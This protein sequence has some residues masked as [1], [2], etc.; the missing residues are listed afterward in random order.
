MHFEVRKG[1]NCL[2]FANKEW[3]TLLSVVEFLQSKTLR[4]KSGQLLRLTHPAVDVRAAAAPPE[5][6]TTDYYDGSGET[7]SSNS[8]SGTPQEH[9]S[10][11]AAG[12]GTASAR[13]S[14]GP[15][16]ESQSGGVPR[17][18]IED[19]FHDTESTQQ[20]R[21][22]PLVHCNIAAPKHFDSNRCNSTVHVYI[23]VLFG[24]SMPTSCILRLLGLNQCITST[25]RQLKYSHTDATF[26]Y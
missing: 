3:N 12:N 6:P 7:T 2:Q 23:T 16:E 5:L 9:E 24:H 22:T 10:D 4:G 15:H 19:T 20:Y 21:R 8:S 17:L 18:Q 14:K 11:D 13:V 1:N 26:V 25:H